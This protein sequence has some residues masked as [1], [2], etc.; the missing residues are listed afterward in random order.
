MR[1]KESIEEKTRENIKHQKKGRK[2]MKNYKEHHTSLTRGYVRVG[3]K[4][5]EEYNGRFGKGYTIKRQ[6]RV[7]GQTLKELREKTGMSQSVFASY[8]GLSVRTLQEWE[9]G[10]QA[11]PAYLLDL[12]D[13]VWTLEREN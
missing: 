12:L 9:Q 1:E 7:P 8:F 4:I 10:N 6:I 5:K 3:Q 2:N 13:R 11:M